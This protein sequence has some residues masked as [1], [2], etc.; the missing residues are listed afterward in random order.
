M[1]TDLCRSQ[2]DDLNNDFAFINKKTRKV[3]CNVAQASQCVEIVSGAQLDALTTRQLG[4]DLRG[5]T[6]NALAHDVF[7]SQNFMP[8]VDYQM[9]WQQPVQKVRDLLLAGWYVVLYVDYGV[10]NQLAP[11]VTGDKNFTG[12]HAIG[13][14]DWWRGPL[15]RSVHYHDPLNDGRHPHTP[16]GVQVVKFSAVRDAAIAFSVNAEHGAAGT[17]YGY[18]VHP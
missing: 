12:Y 5:P 18:A 16:K 3:D 10:M 1:L 15:G 2:L 11:S 13:V 9:L 6:G 7:V 14:S 8:E 4:H 17:V